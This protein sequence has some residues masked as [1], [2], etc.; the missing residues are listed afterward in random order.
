MYVIFSEYF[1]HLVRMDL[2]YY[3]GKRREKETRNE[4]FLQFSFTL[5]LSSEFEIKDSN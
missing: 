2:Y 5:D 1:I 3:S 4:S